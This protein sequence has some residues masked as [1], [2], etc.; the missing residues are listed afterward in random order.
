MRRIRHALLGML[1][2]GAL[3]AATVG[4]AV[5]TTAAQVYG[6]D[7]VY[8]LTFSLNCDNKAS[9]LCAP[10]MS[11]LD[12]VWGWMELDSDHTAD[13]TITFCAHSQGVNGA[14]HQN[15]DGVTWSIV[16]VSGLDG[17]FPVGTDPTGA[18]HRL[19][20]QLGSGR[21]R[22]PGHPGSL[23]DEVRPG[24]HGPG[25]RGADALTG[26]SAP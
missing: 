11:G 12:G 23:L 16:P 18:L 26:T 25:H 5:G 3:I 8:Q 22:L 4:G 21:P 15:V 13:A 9:P 7:H 19:R 1:V 10:D 14:F 24:G 6:S 20:S 2:P 17:N